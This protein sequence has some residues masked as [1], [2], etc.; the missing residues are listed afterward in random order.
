MRPYKEGKPTVVL[1]FLLTQSTIYPSYRLQR[2]GCSKE[3]RNRRCLP[4]HYLDIANVPAA[5]A[6]IRRN[7]GPPFAVRAHPEKPMPAMVQPEWDGLSARWTLPIRFLNFGHTPYAILKVEKQFWSDSMWVLLTWLDWDEILAG[8]VEQ[9][10]YKRIRCWLKGIR[11]VSGLSGGRGTS[12][13]LRGTR[14]VIP[15]SRP[16]FS[17]RTSITRSAESHGLLLLR[18]SQVNSA[19]S[20]ACRT[21]SR[22]AEVISAL[23]LLKGRHAHQVGGARCAHA[24]PRL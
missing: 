24:E 22:A 18:F 12:L 8:D 14:H 21:S 15:R 16:S 1:L 13:T 5:A 6:I 19:A 11:R 9:D 7:G 2:A 20:E 3:T 4:A 23:Y 17:D 10:Y